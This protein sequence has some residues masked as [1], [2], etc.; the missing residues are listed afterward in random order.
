MSTLSESC[1]DDIFTH[2]EDGEQGSRRPVVKPNNY[3]RKSNFEKKFT[4]SY[5]VRLMVG[6]TRKN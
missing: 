5:V 4:L 3:D 1:N 2:V 6:R